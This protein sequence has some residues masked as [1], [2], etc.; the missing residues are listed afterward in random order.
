MYRPFQALFRLTVPLH[1]DPADGLEH[2]LAGMPGQAGTAQQNAE[3]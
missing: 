1:N 3:T 2:Q